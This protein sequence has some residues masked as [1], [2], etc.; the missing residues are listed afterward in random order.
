MEDATAVIL[1]GV[2]DFGRCAIRTELPLAFWRLLDRPIIEY[3]LAHLAQ[4]GVTR[5]VVC[6]NGNTPD[7]GEEVELDGISVRFVADRMP[8]G[9]AGCGRGG[10]LLFYVYTPACGAGG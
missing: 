8:R 2:C 6:T 3:Q 7:L 9:S 1:A 4:Q 5:A 10:L